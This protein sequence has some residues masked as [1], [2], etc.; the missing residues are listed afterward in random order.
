M[1]KEGFRIDGR[2]ELHGIN[3]GLLTAIRSLDYIVEPIVRPSDAAFGDK[4]VIMHC[5]ACPNVAR[6]VQGYIKEAGIEVMSWPEGGTDLNIIKHCCDFV[7]R[8]I[9]KR[10]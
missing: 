2:T 1:V 6:V 8:R 10:E 7:E 4:F 5:N 3:G 9:R